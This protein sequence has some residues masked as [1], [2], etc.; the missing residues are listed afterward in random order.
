MGAGG[1]AGAGGN[2]EAGPRGRGRRRGPRLRRVRRLL[3]APLVVLAVLAPGVALW[4]TW[5]HRAAT[6]TDAFM[7]ST[8]GLATDPTVQDAV[9]R[10][11]VDTVMGRLTSAGVPDAAAL[12]PRV[13]AIVAR[14]PEHAAYRSAWLAT[15]RTVHQRLAARL[16]GTTDD[17]LTLPLDATAAV[18]RE[19][20]SAAGLGALAAQVPDPAPVVVADRAEVHRARQA[21]D[22]VGTLQSVTVPAA[23]VAL[24]GVA[25]AAGGV[26]RGLRRAGLCLAVSMGL[27]LGA[28][29]LGHA[30]A[31]DT[32]HGALAAAVYD[33]VSTPLWRWALAGLAAGLAATALGTVLAG[34]GGRPHRYP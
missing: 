8:A 16:D 29:A 3:A 30:G 17:P 28:W 1:G 13:E 11:L 14:L 6:D 9:G 20:L 24:L 34:R 21:T 31:A 23:V 5:A 18:L 10:E 12:R 26:G 33:A 19:R 4:T 22:T 15:Q 27:T 2:A 32:E 25:I 7:D